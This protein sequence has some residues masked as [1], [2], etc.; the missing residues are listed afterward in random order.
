[1][2]RQNENRSPRLWAKPSWRKEGP[3]A[4]LYSAA[5]PSPKRRA[6]QPEKGPTFLKMYV[7]PMLLLNLTV[8]G[9][10]LVTGL[11]DAFSYLV[12]G[13]VFVANMTGN[14]VFLA[15]ALA[16]APG[17]SILASLVALGAFVLGSLGGGL[18][19][20]HLGQHRGHLLS[21]AAALQALLL[22][23]A[24]VLAAVSGNPVSPGFSSGL[25]IVLG[26]AMG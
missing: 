9:W 26:V 1:M 20:S 22:A 8:V 23:A 18:L 12:L 16:G 3:A 5:S 6:C 17:F 7:I 21:V 24:V 19:G 4:P 2:I 11:V 14:V 15:F 10:T 25:I 13:H